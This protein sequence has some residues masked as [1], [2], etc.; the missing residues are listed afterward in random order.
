MI[1]IRV[2][3]RG[4][5]V[6][7]VPSYEYERRSGESNL[8]TVRDGFRVLRTILGE[9]VSRRPVV[10]RTGVPTPRHGE[11]TTVPVR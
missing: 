7:E 6:V 3:T 5:V 1:N 4:A 8:N 10:A 2:V 9:R 11:S